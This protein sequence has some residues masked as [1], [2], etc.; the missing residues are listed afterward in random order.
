[1]GNNTKVNVQPLAWAESPV[2]AHWRWHF[3]KKDIRIDIND[4]FRP[5]ILSDI[6][7][8]AKIHE[9]VFVRKD[10][11]LIR[12]RPSGLLGVTLPHIE[13][14]VQQET[15]GVVGLNTMD[16]HADYGHFELKETESAQLDGVNAR[17]PES[18]V[19]S[20]TFENTGAHLVDLSP[21]E[22]DIS[23]L[24]EMK[25]RNG[26]FY[27]HPLS[28]MRVRPMVDSS[29]NWD[30][31]FLGVENGGSGTFGTVF[32]GKNGETVEFAGVKQQILNQKLHLPNVVCILWSD[33]R[34]GPGRNTCHCA[35]FMV[36]WLS[37]DM[38]L[39]H[40]KASHYCKWMQLLVILVCQKSKGIPWFTGGVR[41][42]LPWMAPRTPEM[43]AA[44]RLMC[45]LSALSLWE[46]LTEPLCQYALRSNHSVGHLDPLARPSFTEITRRFTL[47]CQQQEH[48]DNSWRN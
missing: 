46:I 44:V 38:H 35:E 27:T 18:E 8:Q 24:H 16:S 40:R 14:D 29:T 23:T 48:G 37:L 25:R 41:G 43:V 6:F 17:I 13:E 1:M 4:R 36:K 22:F 34:M 33:F 47:K 26:L 19:G 11:S 12:P 7:S 32:H 45:S 30:V 42:T 15:S 9:N 39:D 28:S 3:E 31:L 20:W 10:F 5:D 21:G 2:R